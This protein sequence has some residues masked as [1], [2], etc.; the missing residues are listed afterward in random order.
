[1]WNYEILDDLILNTKV[2]RAL[3]EK[4]DI[5]YQWITTIVVKIIFLNIYIYIWIWIEMI[6]CI[7]TFCCRKGK[8]GKTCWFLTLLQG[9]WKLYVNCGVINQTNTKA[10]RLQTQTEHG[11][12]KNISMIKFIKR[13]FSM[14][15]YS[16]AVGVG[17]GVSAQNWQN[18]QVTPGDFHL[19]DLKQ[20]NGCWSCQTPVLSIMNW[21]QPG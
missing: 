15:H 18:R 21:T 4:Q 19:L 8:S 11:A 14:T 7:S 9:Y 6:L 13:L 16:E 12:K 17:W 5:D 2:R 10:Q 1:M 3:D 20:K